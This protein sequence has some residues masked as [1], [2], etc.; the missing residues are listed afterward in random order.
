MDGGRE[1][2]Y[3]P[4]RK[5]RGLS[6]C[7]GGEGP[8][9][10]ILSVSLIGAPLLRSPGMRASR[11]SAL[12]LCILAPLSTPLSPRPLPPLHSTPSSLVLSSLTLLSRP[13]RLCVSGR[14]SLRARWGGSISLGLV[15]GRG[16]LGLVGAR[17]VPPLGLEGLL[18][19]WLRGDGWVG[20]SS[21][22][23]GQAQ[24][25]PGGGQGQSDG[26][27]GWRSG[28]LARGRGAR[29]LGAI[30]FGHD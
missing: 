8:L 15:R 18:D 9:S 6:S 21:V 23:S 4:G 1:G 28:S 30:A 25:L 19:L 24:Q 17:L 10:V 3:P 5:R 22:T 7:G 11:A 14:V 26:R 2:R 12:P 13:P 29:S 16:S 27:Q 20:R